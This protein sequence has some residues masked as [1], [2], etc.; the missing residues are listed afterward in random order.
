MQLLLCLLHI[1]VEPHDLLWR[2][3]VGDG[4]TWSYASWASA[5]CCITL[6]VPALNSVGYPLALPG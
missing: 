2:A 1:V 5:G 3:V 4:S 6:L